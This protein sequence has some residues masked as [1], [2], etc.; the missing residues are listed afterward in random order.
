MLFPV[1]DRDIPREGLGGDWVPHGESGGWGAGT[2][3][4]YPSAHAGPEI[5]A[6][7]FEDL[8]LPTSEEVL[9]GL[10]AARGR[11]GPRAEGGA[12]AGLSGGRGRGR[13]HANTK[14]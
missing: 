4:N 8:G 6:S 11:G 9:T 5:P 13:A 12:G 2:R 10:C 1:S 7:E 14:G 3:T